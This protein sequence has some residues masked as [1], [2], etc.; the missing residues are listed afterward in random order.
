[1]EVCMQDWKNHV[2][3]GGAL[4]LEGAS[5]PSV[6]S[7]AD[8]QVILD[9]ASK[10]AE[11]LVRGDEELDASSWVTTRIGACHDGERALDRHIRT[12]EEGRGRSR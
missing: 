11:G 8:A 10:A 7:E 2:V 12:L 6:G 1:M 3:A 4:G 9:C 5:D